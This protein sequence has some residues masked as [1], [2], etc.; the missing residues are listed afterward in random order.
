MVVKLVKEVRRLSK[1]IH[2]RNLLLDQ[3][4]EV[5]LGIIGHYRKAVAVW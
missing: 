3:L 5:R 4:D 1:S 2:E